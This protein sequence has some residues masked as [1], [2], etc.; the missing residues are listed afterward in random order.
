[1]FSNDIKLYK[2][3]QMKNMKKIDLEKYVTT[4]QQQISTTIKEDVI[5]D[6]IENHPIE[7]PDSQKKIQM[8]LQT[9]GSSQASFAFKKPSLSKN[10][11][12]DNQ[13]VPN[14]NLEKNTKTQMEENASQLLFGDMN[15][16]EAYSMDNDKENVNPA[17]LQS[18]ADEEFFDN[19]DAKR[20]KTKKAS[21]KPIKDN[22]EHDGAKEI[23]PNSVE[24]LV[25]SIVMKN[26]GIDDNYEPDDDPDS[27]D[28]F[29]PSDSSDNDSDEDPNE[30]G[31]ANNY[32]DIGQI[33]DEMEQE[34]E[35]YFSN[36][37]EKEIDSIIDD[38]LMNDNTTNNIKEI[39]KIDN[40]V[41]DGQRDGNKH[42]ETIP[43]PKE[44]IPQSKETEVHNNERD[45]LGKN[46]NEQG[47][48]NQKNRQSANE[49]NDNV[50]PENQPMQNNEN[51]ILGGPGY[52]KLGKRKNTVRG[53][54][55]TIKL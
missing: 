14:P 27:R 7:E 21:K 38:V 2:I 41:D 22:S 4:F 12:N 43:D 49:Q 9:C 10:H 8:E 31:E 54:E 17:Y 39:G 29:I 23:V 45:L 50:Q 51:I 42:A 47:I 44:H 20:V 26:C 3:L 6:T 36:D 18:F 35:N 33:H 46:Q 40:P 34:L 11:K 13:D 15:S 52:H 53:Q 32:Q 48:A 55:Y 25:P 28:E 24:L 19:D 37:N 30:D 1:M 5:P 16:L